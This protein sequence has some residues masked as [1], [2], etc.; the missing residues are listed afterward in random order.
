M[1]EPDS[2]G[3]EPTLLYPELEVP[4]PY[5]VPEVPLLQAV[6]PAARAAI[7]AIVRNGRAFP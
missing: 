3:L 2:L 5:C 4:S 7:A 1:R 6:I